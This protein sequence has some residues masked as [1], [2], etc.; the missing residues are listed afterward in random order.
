MSRPCSSSRVV[1]RPRGLLSITTIRSARVACAPSISIWS[2]PWR[3]GKSGSR[4]LRPFTR[5]RPS[6]TQAAACVLEPSP[7]FEITR[8]TPCLGGSDGDGDRRFSLLTGLDRRRARRRSPAASGTGSAAGL[9]LATRMPLAFIHASNS[10]AVMR[11]P[12]WLMSKRQGVLSSLVTACR[13]R[14]REPGARSR[15]STWSTLW[16]YGSA[17][18]ATAISGATTLMFAPAGRRREGSSRWQMP[19]RRRRSCRAARRGTG[20]SLGG[21]RTDRSR[22]VPRASRRQQKSPARGRAFS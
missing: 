9:P 20:F 19:A 21:S 6:A 12:F 16:Q 15:A 3:T 18:V 4:T 5:T 14:R 2:T 17:E 10:S 8:A 11:R 1:S 22:I 13:H 7:S